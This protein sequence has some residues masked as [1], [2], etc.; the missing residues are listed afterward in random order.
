[1]AA[2]P[3][4]VSEELWGPVEPLLPRKGR[5]FRYPGRRRLPDREALQGIL[6]VLHTGMACAICRSSS[7]SARER[8]VTGAWTSGSEPARGR[9]CTRFCSHG[10]ERRGRSS[11]RARSPTRAKS[12]R[13]KGLR[14]GPEPGGQ[15]PCGLQAPPPRRGERSPSRL[16]PDGRQSQ[17]RHAADPAP[18]RRAGGARCGRPSP[19]APRA[20]ERRSRLRPRQVPPP[21][22]GAGHQ[23]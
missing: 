20:A 22:A 6:F 15:R 3:W 16:A 4:I 7:A 8:P 1:M 2:A 11:G 9:P 18:R 23:A 10:C 17:R 19:A 12:R 21:P 13:K 5:R 14:D